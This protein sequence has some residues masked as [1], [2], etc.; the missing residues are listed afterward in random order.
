MPPARFITAFHNALVLPAQQ[1]QQQYAAMRCRCAVAALAPPRPPAFAA[2]AFVVVVGTARR[3]V[4]GA[5]DGCAARRHAARL[6]FS[7]AQQ[8]RASARGRQHGL[9]FPETAASASTAAASRS[10]RSAGEHSSPAYQIKLLYDGECPLCMKE[11][12]FLRARD[13]ARGNIAFVDIA[14]PDYE[15]A[16]H[17]GVSYEAGMGRVH[18]VLPDGAVVTDLDV[19]R[20]CYE[21]VGLGWA[22]SITTL[23]GM[24]RVADALYDL[25]A[26]RRLQWTG[27]ES[28]EAVVAE[29]RRRPHGSSSSDCSAR[30]AADGNGDGNAGK[31]GL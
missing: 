8:T 13:G 9:P 2:A 18:G 11:V 22:W 15:P 3:K 26:A 31:K 21:A 1:Q 30:C 27:R 28:L 17:G 23:P 24:R 6:P 20:R 14:A 5:A 4:T 29:R 10:S 16:E 19:F 12:R 7:V 25:W